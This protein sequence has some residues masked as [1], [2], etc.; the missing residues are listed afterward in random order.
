MVSQS[1]VNDMVWGKTPAGVYPG[2]LLA[3]RAA[4]TTGNRVTLVMDDDTSR[5]GTVIRYDAYDVDIKMDNGTCV[6]MAT[7]NVVKVFDSGE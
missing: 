4:Y 1:Q 2:A 6:H 3:L 5:T 7:D